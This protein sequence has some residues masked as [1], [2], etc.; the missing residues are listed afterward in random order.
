MKRWCLGND[1]HHMANTF[2]VSI[3]LISH[4]I[5]IEMDRGLMTIGRPKWAQT[6]SLSEIKSVAALVST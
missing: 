4:R 1:A 6:K 3:V 5:Y 2:F